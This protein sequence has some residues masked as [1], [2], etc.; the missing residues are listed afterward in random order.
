MYL[1]QLLIHTF[2]LTLRCLTVRVTSDLQ[3]LTFHILGHA[4]IACDSDTHVSYSGLLRVLYSS[5]GLLSDICAT[6]DILSIVIRHIMSGRE[7]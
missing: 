7:I 2:T 4:K 1:S 6:C 3:Q 5:Y